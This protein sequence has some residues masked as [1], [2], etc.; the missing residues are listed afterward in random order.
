MISTHSI[1]P[2]FCTRHGSACNAIIVQTEWRYNKR[3]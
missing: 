1:T 3:R 2:F